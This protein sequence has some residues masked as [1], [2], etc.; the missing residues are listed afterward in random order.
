MQVLVI[1]TRKGLFVA[2][3]EGAGYRVA[4]Q[5]FA[6]DNVTLAMIDPRG[7]WYAALNHGHFGVKL[8]RSDD[9][10]ATWTEIAAP[11]YPP[12]PADSTDKAKWTT[13]LVWALAPAL[14]RDGALWCGTLP[15]GLFRSEDRARRGSLRV[16]VVYLTQRPPGSAV[17]RM[18]LAFTRSRSIRAIRTPSSSRSAAV[19]SGDRAAAARPGR[20]RLWACAWRT[21]RPS[22]PTIRTS[23]IRT[24]SSSARHSHT[25]GGRNTTTASSDRPTIWRPDRARERRPIDVWLPRGRRSLSTATPRGSCPPRAIRS[26]FPSAASSW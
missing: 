24:A 2:E 25:C 14:D 12:Q 8:H 18:I 26:A 20:I 23:R 7:G 13:S 3:P 16:A 22:A 9:R 19:A 15:G 4:R 5:S 17:A 10:G 6:G 11:K 1:S 21:C